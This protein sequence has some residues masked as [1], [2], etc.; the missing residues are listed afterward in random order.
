MMTIITSVS[1]PASP[2]TP[3]EQFV[4]LSMIQSIAPAHGT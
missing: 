3:S 4:A 1:V 2:S